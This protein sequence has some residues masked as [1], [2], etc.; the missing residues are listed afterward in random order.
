MQQLKSRIESCRKRMLGATVAVLVL[1]GSTTVWAQT[2]PLCYRAAAASKA[3]A[4]AALR[5]G[6]LILM[7]PP[8]AIFGI[9][10]WIAIRRRDRFNEADEVRPAQ[11]PE[12]DRE[13]EALEALVEEDHAWR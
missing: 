6:V 3:G 1:L 7:L 13:L 12:P 10:T 8:V 2:C 4:I 11:T 5:R 9:V